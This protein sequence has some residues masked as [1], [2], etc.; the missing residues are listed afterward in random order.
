MFLVGW[1]NKKLANKLICSPC[2]CAPPL[3]PTLSSIAV[4]K[5]NPLRQEV[6]WG[7]EGTAGDG[8]QVPSHLPL[9]RTGLYRFRPTFPWSMQLKCCMMWL[10]WTRRHGSKRR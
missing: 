3:L 9:E 6:V 8:V 7:A 5:T 4:L 2:S 10:R 1:S